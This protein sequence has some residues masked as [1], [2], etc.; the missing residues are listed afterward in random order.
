MHKSNKISW[1]LFIRAYLCR[2]YTVTYSGVR[3]CVRVMYSNYSKASFI[4][5]LVFKS[6]GG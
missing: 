5:T 2:T 6:L 3:A 4:H 1:R